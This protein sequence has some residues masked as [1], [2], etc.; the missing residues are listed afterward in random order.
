MGSRSGGGGF[1]RRRRSE[2]ARALVLDK[3]GLCGVHGVGKRGLGLGCYASGVSRLGFLAWFRVVAIV[4]WLERVRLG[5]MWQIEVERSYGRGIA[6][7][8]ET[9]KSLPRAQD[10]W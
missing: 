7:E 10:G 9:E 6:G 3:A 8:S 4:T 1:E 5:W 2:V